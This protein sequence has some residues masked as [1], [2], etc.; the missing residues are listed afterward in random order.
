MKGLRFAGVAGL[1]AMALLLPGIVAAQPVSGLYVAGAGGVNQRSEGVVTIGP[2]LTAPAQA[3][4]P[5]TTLPSPGS[6]SG[7]GSTGLGSIGF[8]FG[9]GFRLEVEGSRRGR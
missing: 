9:N 4:P 2:A 7:V 6:G 3:S 5:G 8:G 1:A